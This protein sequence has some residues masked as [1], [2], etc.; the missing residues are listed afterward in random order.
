MQRRHVLAA[1]RLRGAR[2]VERPGTPRRARLRVNDARA[3]LDGALAQRTWELSDRL[4]RS[5]GLVLP[6]VGAPA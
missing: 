3:A 4:A 6:E 2:A 5:R 1:Q